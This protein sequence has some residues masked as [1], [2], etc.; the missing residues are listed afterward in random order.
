MSRPEVNMNDLDPNI[1]APKL[2]PTPRKSERERKNISYDKLNKGAANSD[3][4]DLELR[5]IGK[6]KLE[7]MRSSY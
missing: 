3:E 5:Q 1:E 6:N 4:D 7:K 2:S